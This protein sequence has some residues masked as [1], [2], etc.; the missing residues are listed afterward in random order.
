MWRYNLRSGRGWGVGA[1]YGPEGMTSSRGPS[2][3]QGRETGWA[4]GCEFKNQRSRVPDLVRGA[5]YTSPCLTLWAAPYDVRRVPRFT[6]MHTEEE[7]EVTC[8]RAVTMTQDPGSRCTAWRPPGQ[9]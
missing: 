4:G 9:L 1:E 2:D 8:P 3:P 6:P 7:K 5:L